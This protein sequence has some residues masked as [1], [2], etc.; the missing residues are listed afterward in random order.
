VLSFAKT[1]IISLKNH[2]DFDEKWVGDRIA[3]DPTILG[4]GELRLIDRE[5]RQERAGR[6]DLLLEDADEELRYEV[7]LM[8]GP[9]DESHVVR[10]IEYWDIE[11][12]RYPAYEH[13]A[14]LVA[15]DVTA[16]FLNVLSL[17]AGSVPLIAIQL[18]AIEVEGKVSLVPVKVLDARALLREDLEVAPTAKADRTQWAESS[19]KTLDVVDGCLALINEKSDKKFEANYTQAY[20]GLLD[21]NRPRVFITFW[22][23]KIGASVEVVLGE[24]P[25]P[26]VTRLRGEGMNAKAL[27]P[28]KLRVLVMQSDLESLPKK[29]AL[30]EFLSAAVRAYL[31]S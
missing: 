14:V 25:E 13:C 1:E 24:D 30:S 16:R 7:E 2:Q 29:Q 19:P 9:A 28:E 31:S 21:G 4:L 6:L 15:E 22:P 20:I 8:L 5:R 11:R 17:I 18:T 23:R 10:C 27:G 3:E 12:R 26:W